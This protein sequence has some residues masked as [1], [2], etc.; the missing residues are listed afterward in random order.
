MDASERRGSPTE[1]VPDDDDEELASVKSE[2][3]GSGGTRG[4]HEPEGEE[5][6]NVDA[7]G[8]S[9]G[10]SKRAREPGASG[11]PLR[12]RRDARGHGGELRSRNLSPGDDAPVTSKE[13]RELLNQHLQS[14][15]AGWQQM[16]TRLDQVEQK[17]KQMTDKY[18]G[19]HKTM[20]VVKK[21]RADLHCRVSQIER[22]EAD[23]EVKISGLSK[24][25]DELKKK[26]N[27]SKPGASLPSDPW[28]DYRAKHGATVNNQRGSVPDG[29]LPPEH[30]GA[31]PRPPVPLGREE[32]SDDDK[33]TLIFGGWLQD[34]KKQIILDESKPFLQKDVVAALVDQEELMVWGPR[35]SFGALRF[36]YRDGESYANVKD[37]MWKVI[38]HLRANPLLLES[39]GADRKQLWAQF[40]KTKEARRRSAHGSLIR[41]VCTNLVKDA[42]LNK[43]AHNPLGADDSAY[44]V[45]WNAGSV[46]LGEWKIGSSA[47]RA[48]KG[49]SVK[50]LS[51]G[52]I[53]VMSMATATGVGFDLALAAV[54]REL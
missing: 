4:L 22:K 18:G 16:N 6:M 7:T 44:D 24:V 23:L 31:S 41:R 30:A 54:E 36:K 10:R 13:F 19:M 53:D 35:R 52:W 43:E 50:L 3:E 32:L 1:I 11:D 29:T 39:T 46:W 42:Q 15:S 38:Q 5:V 49:D 2:H 14:M 40:A 51:S 45:D 28:A 8:G 20:E 48:P 17:E 26:D 37:R 27:N 25:V 47:H 21:D 12:H 9:P 34:T 33:R